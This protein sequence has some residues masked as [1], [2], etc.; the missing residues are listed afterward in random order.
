MNDPFNQ[1]LPHTAEAQ[2]TVL[3]T[4]FPHSV[5]INHELPKIM[6]NDL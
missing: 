4:T 5:A 1:E 6:E 2:P 3:P